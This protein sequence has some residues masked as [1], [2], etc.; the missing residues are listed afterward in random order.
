[1]DVM[2]TNA[3]SLTSTSS[4]SG[5]G[6]SSSANRSGS[7]SPATLGDISALEHLMPTAET[8]VH[9]AS[10]QKRP[11]RTTPSSIPPTS[12]SVPTSS[13]TTAEIKRALKTSHSLSPQFPSPSSRLRSAQLAPAAQGGATHSA[14]GGGILN[15]SHDEDEPKYALVPPPPTTTAVSPFTSL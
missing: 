9:K 12:P 13:E 4:A 3:G 8:P 7:Q 14:T 1:M 11:G 6:T 2:P 15:T 5:P 10:P